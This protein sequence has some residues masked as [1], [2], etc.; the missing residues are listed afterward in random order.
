MSMMRNEIYERCSEEGYNMMRYGMSGGFSMLLLLIIG[1]LIIFLIVSNSKN[2]HS[3]RPSSSAL[4][5]L[6]KELAKGNISEEE[7]VRKRDLL[8]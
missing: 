3:E 4:E 7:Y 5:I 6:E 8:K 1:G 2:K